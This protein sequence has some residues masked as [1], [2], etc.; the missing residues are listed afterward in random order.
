MHGTARFPK[1]RQHSKKGLIMFLPVSTFVVSL[2]AILLV[3]LSFRVI[4]CR[5]QNQVNLGDGGN[6]TLQRRIRGQA[7]F[8][9]YAPLGALLV[10]VAEL[11]SA[12]M[13]LLL[14]AAILFLIGRLFHAYAFGFMDKSIRLRVWGM[15]L[16]FLGLGALVLVSIFAMLPK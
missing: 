10:L 9:E 2:L 3:V 16:T 7:N 13:F 15:Q 12:P 4:K 1:G 8:A 5:Q 11:Q 6:E 14:P